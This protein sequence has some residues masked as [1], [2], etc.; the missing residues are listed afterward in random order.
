MNRDYDPR[1]LASSSTNPEILMELAIQRSL[2]CPTP[3]GRNTPLPDFK[4]QD[5][6]DFPQLCNDA[7]PVSS[8]VYPCETKEE[9]DEVVG[10]E[11]VI[12]RPKTP[13]VNF[14]D[15]KVED[16][17]PAKTE[18]LWNVPVKEEPKDIQKMESSAA[19]ALITLAEQDNIIRHKSPGPIHPNIIRTLESMSNKYINDEPILRESEKIEM[20]SEIPTTDSE[21]ES[22]EI[23]RLRY[24]NIQLNIL[25]IKLS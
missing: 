15:F 4:I 3:T 14:V 9:R 18:N 13:D 24:L 7:S 5:P 2:D 10:R 12:G 21:E 11:T 17:L 22:L 6:N 1:P 23:R 16:T 25:G 8:P 19:E 20:F